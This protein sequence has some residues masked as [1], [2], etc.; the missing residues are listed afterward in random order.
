MKFVFFQFQRR[1][2]G[3]SDEGTDGG[4]ARQNFWARTAPDCRYYSS[5]THTFVLL[6]PPLS[7]VKQLSRGNHMSSLVFLFGCRCF[8][9]VPY[10]GKLYV[11][12]G[13]SE[14]LSKKMKMR[15]KRELNQNAMW[16]VIKFLQFVY[17][18]VSFSGKHYVFMFGCD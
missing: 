16:S 12:G 6:S 18:V 14:K 13:E 8:C 4:N 17:S 10:K 9:A 7:Y 11:F 5:C 2:N 15:G 3:L 1:E